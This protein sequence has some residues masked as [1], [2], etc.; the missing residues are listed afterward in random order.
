MLRMML[1]GVLLFVP[2]LAPGAEGPA[3]AS[4]RQAQWPRRVLAERLQDRAG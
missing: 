2:G 1:V 3:R 4:R